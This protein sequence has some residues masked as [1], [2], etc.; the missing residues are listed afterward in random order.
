M[1]KKEFLGI[2][3]IFCSEI[4]RF[5][6][7]AVLLE[8]FAQTKKAK[9][10]C[11]LGT[12]CGIIP[13][14]MLQNNENIKVTAV[15]IQKDAIDLVKKAVAENGA[16][17]SIFPINCDLKAIPN[18]FRCKFDLVTINPPYKRKG[19]GKI[20]GINGIDIAR[21]EIEC[22]L[23]DICVCAEKILIPNGKFCICQ[24][25]ER[26]GEVIFEMKKAGIEPKTIRFV[27]NKTADKPMLVLISGIKGAN[28]GN[29]I[30][31]DLVLKNDDNSDTFEVENIYKIMRGKIN[32]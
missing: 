26:F 11:D 5:G 1:I 17:N 29:E 4:H 19:A 21:N 14:L 24:R 15:D 28:V 20:T 31:P 12:G 32:G 18:E 7:D 22:D 23:K 9:N 8:Y 25:P 6:T 10:A 2:Y 27:K 16:E 30:L 13:F 3:N